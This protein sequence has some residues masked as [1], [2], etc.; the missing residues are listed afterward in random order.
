[1]GGDGQLWHSVLSLYG[2]GGRSDTGD[3][4]YSSASLKVAQGPRKLRRAV[5]ASPQSV[6][7]AV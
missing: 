4:F 2:E 3:L 1:M 7:I 5:D 6:H